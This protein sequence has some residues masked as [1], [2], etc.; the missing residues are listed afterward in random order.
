MDHCSDG[1]FRKTGYT[2]RFSTLRSG[3]AAC[4]ANPGTELGGRHRAFTPRARS[5]RKLMFK[6]VCGH[7]W[8]S[9]SPPE[10][11]HSTTS[12]TG[13]DGIGASPAAVPAPSERLSP[14]KHP[15]A[16]ASAL[17]SWLNSRHKADSCGTGDWGLRLD[18]C[19]SVPVPP[20][21]PPPAGAPYPEPK[22]ALPL[23]T[24]SACVHPGP[25]PGKMDALR[26][27]GRHVSGIP[28]FLTR[29]GPGLS[30]KRVILRWRSSPLGP[31]SRSPA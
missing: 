4:S 31:G 21:T 28:P 12:C 5:H 10:D 29:F 3:T 11:C 1:G 27:I 14:C 18:G 2:R 24:P 9:C 15:R 20:S 6:I 8:M 23:N 22:T 17:E 7:D 25:D 30:K 13:T 19:P 16:T 26:R